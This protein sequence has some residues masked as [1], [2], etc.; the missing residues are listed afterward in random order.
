MISRYVKFV[1]ENYKT[2]YFNYG[3]R[4]FQ[5]DISYVGDTTKVKILY[6]G[7]NYEDLFVIVPD[8]KDLGKDEF[9]IN[10]NLE[11]DMIEELERQGFIEC[12]DKIS[13]AG[14]KETKSYRII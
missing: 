14:D 12:T 9:F 5:L 11:E 8:T 6:M 10:P 4:P 2:G 13:M 7:K 1:N 3:D